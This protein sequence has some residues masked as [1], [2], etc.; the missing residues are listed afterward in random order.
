[1]QKNVTSELTYFGMEND[2]MTENITELVNRTEKIP[3]EPCTTDCNTM[4]LYLLFR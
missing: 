2:T 4:F 3:T 1:M